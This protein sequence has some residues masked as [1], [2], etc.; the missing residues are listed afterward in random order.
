[1]I[2]DFYRLNSVN[3]VIWNVKDLTQVGKNDR[4]TKSSWYLRDSGNNVNKLRDSG[5]Y[6]KLVRDSGSRPPLPD[7]V[8]ILQF[9]KFLPFYIPPAWKRY[10][11][12]AEP[13]HIVHYRELPPPPPPPPG[14]NYQDRRVINSQCH[15]NRYWV[16]ICFLGQ[17][18]A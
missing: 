12:W 10:P 14:K 3:S 4:Q 16:T 5:I 15:A 17:V 2:R 18:V 11:F 9:V 1:M 6:E 8:C 13:P 7:P